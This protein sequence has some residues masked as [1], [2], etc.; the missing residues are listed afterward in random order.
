MKNVSWAMRRIFAV[1]LALC[2]VCATA[3]AAEYTLKFGYG[4]PADPNTSI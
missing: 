4:E 3:F 1:V 2:L